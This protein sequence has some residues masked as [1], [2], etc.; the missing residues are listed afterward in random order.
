MEWLP[1]RAEPG[2]NVGISSAIGEPSRQKSMY[3]TWCP[4]LDKA[5]AAE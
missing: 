4:K 3:W 1:I 2:V 5:P